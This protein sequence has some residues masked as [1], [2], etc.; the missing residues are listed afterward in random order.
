MG[1]A[2][3]CAALVAGCGGSGSSTSASAPSANSSTSAESSRSP[4]GTLIVGLKDKCGPGPS[5]GTQQF[6]DC[7]QVAKEACHAKLDPGKLEKPEHTEQ[8]LS[9]ALVEKSKNTADTEAP[10]NTEGFN[11]KGGPP[12]QEE[13]APEYAWTLPT[14]ADFK[15][16]G[17][18][19]ISQAAKIESTYDAS[20]APKVTQPTLQHAYEVAIRNA[21]AHSTET[22]APVARISTEVRARYEIE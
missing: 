3:V 9:C 20:Q 14:C 7:L 5:P 17:A 2:A 4:W 10:A 12:D 15:L 16:H 22:Y 21:C 6:K 8:A 11:A 13:A 19:W 18:P 1:V